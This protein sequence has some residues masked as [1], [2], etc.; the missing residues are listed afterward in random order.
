[1]E[2]NITRPTTTWAR[3]RGAEVLVLL[4][5]A[6]AVGWSVIALSVHSPDPAFDPD[7]ATDAALARLGA[8]VMATVAAVAA[9]LWWRHR[10]A[11]RRPGHGA[12]WARAAFAVS[13]V[14]VVAVLP[15]IALA[16]WG[17]SAPLIAFTCA[18]LTFGVREIAAPATADGRAGR[19]ARL[20]GRAAVVER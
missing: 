9:S 18:V 4:L 6:A 20:P 10:V 1:M 8:G 19:A 17:W 7:G 16:S 12:G 15:M 5:G 3:P 14:H 2:S 13:T 11:G